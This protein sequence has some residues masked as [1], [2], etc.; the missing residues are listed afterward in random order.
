MPSSPMVL[1]ESILDHLPSLSQRF[2]KSL[3]DL[4]K[5]CRAAGQPAN[6]DFGELVRH[7]RDF[8]WT[9]VGP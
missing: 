2:G 6:S 9:V 4:E 3:A 8:A 5:R 7:A 1:K